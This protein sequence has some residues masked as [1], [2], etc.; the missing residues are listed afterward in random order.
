M[1]FCFDLPSKWEFMKVKMAFKTEKSEKIKDKQR[2]DCQ[3][4]PDETMKAILNFFKEK[5]KF[6]DQYIYWLFSNFCGLRI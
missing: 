2:K 5:N 6:E 3:F 1:I 4:I